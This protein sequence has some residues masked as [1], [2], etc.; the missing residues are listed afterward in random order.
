M[1]RFARET[2]FLLLHNVINTFC[3]CRFSMWSCLFSANQFSVGHSKFASYF[4]ATIASELTDSYVAAS[5]L[6][7][8]LLRRT[9][10]RNN[11]NMFTA[12]LNPKVAADAIYM[13]IS[14]SMKVGIKRIRH[15]NVFS[16]IFQGRCISG[17]LIRSLIKAQYSIR[18]AMA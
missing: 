7:M 3:R 11:P 10:Y 14:V 6:L 17:R 12:T 9:Q 5:G 13:T 8:V 15:P 1:K 2:K 4:S 18:S 16:G